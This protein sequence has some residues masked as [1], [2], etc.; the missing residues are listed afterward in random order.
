MAIDFDPYAL[1]PTTDTARQ[2]LAP[3]STIYRLRDMLVFHASTPLPERC[4][5]TNLPTCHRF[6][7]NFAYQT[8]MSKLTFGFL[9]S[10]FYR[11]VVVYIGLT[12]ERDLARKRCVRYGRFSK[13]LGLMLMMSWI[14][15]APTP[16]A[17]AMF[18][19]GMALFLVA[20]FIDSYSC[21]IVYANKMQAGYV[22]LKG[23]CPAYLDEYEQ[24]PS[25]FYR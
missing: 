16:S 17:F 14:P 2:S 6:K 5:K 22:Y 9:S 10:A 23:V 12:N 20:K 18:L 7:Q 21:R 15:L 25:D 3:T 8:S 11:N 1:P 13:S 24:L 19:L 4:V